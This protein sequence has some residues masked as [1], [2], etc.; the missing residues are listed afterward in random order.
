MKEHIKL[1]QV[2]KLQEGFIFN[3]PAPIPPA[4]LSPKCVQAKDEINVPIALSAFR[5]NQNVLLAEVL[6]ISGSLT[7]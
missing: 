2:Y 4:P 7:T 5:D 3:N 6:F 1:V